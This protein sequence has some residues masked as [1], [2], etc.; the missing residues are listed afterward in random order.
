MG[1]MKYWLIAGFIILLA[2]VY[3]AISDRDST[4]S[5]LKSAGENGDVE[6]QYAL[7][8]MYLYG[9]ILDVDYQQAKI[10]YE[11]A[12]AQNDPRAQAKLGVMYANG[13]GVKQDYQQS[14]SWYQK[15]AVQ[16]EVNA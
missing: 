5:R 11:K 10:W 1:Q 15:A 6:A 16:N 2:I 13:L 3:T 8:L 4:L 7:G 9:E 12:A 14:K